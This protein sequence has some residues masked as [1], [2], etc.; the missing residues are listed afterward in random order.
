MVVLPVRRDRNPLAI[1]PTPP[2]PPPLQLSS[3]G[4]DE[5]IGGEGGVIGDTLVDFVAS[6]PALVT[7]AVETIGEKA[8]FSLCWSR[9]WA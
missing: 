8:D 2:P 1:F 9:W 6:P 5:S 7:A 3:D 4:G